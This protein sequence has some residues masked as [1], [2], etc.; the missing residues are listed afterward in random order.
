MS[1]I[2]ALAAKYLP[3][4]VALLNRVSVYKLGR[5]QFG[6]GITYFPKDSHFGRSLFITVGKYE[7]ALT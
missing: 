4:I 5:G 3:T 2:A 6:L 7:I 1:K